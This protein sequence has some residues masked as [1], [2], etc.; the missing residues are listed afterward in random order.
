M[1]EEAAAQDSVGRDNRPVTVTETQT[2]NQVG[3]ALAVAEQKQSH[4]PEESDAR[5]D[6]GVNEAVLSLQTLINAATLVDGWLGE[7]AKAIPSDKASVAHTDSAQNKISNASQSGKRRQKSNAGEYACSDPSCDKTYKFITGL[8]RHYARSGHGASAEPSSEV[9][10]GHCTMES[11]GDIEANLSKDAKLSQDLKS[12]HD[13]TRLKREQLR[14]ENSKKDSG[15]TF[16][17]KGPLKNE[18]KPP[19]SRFDKGDTI[20]SVYIDGKIILESRKYNEADGPWKPVKVLDHLP[21]LYVCA[22]CKKR[23][24]TPPK[25]LNT[26]SKIRHHI[27]TFHGKTIPIN[28]YPV[29]CR[30]WDILP[31]NCTRAQV[32]FQSGDFLPIRNAPQEEIETLEKNWTQG[33]G[34]RKEHVNDIPEV[35]PV[36]SLANF[37]KESTN[38]PKEFSDTDYSTSLHEDTP[39]NVVKRGQLF[40]MGNEGVAKYDTWCQD[41][42]RHRFLWRG[43]S[44]IKTPQCPVLSKDTLNV[45]I[46]YSMAYKDKESSYYLYISDEHFAEYAS[47]MNEVNHRIVKL[48]TL[49]T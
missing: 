18:T 2:K 12:W 16:N 41:L 11:P 49:E 5:N 23:G 14:A 19:P 48:G 25:V 33:E 43:D 31:K 1:K 21:L 8:N 20:L 46:T 6:K 36:Q 39:K 3:A 40:N 42:E 45:K 27:R 15:K 30:R 32:C 28:W 24:K 7:N 10:V 47:V 35:K 26:E 22:I 29:L 9:E 34:A 4:H 38:W 17:E 44:E 13:E 37:I